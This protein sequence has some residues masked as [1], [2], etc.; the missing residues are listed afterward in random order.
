VP[1]G[2]APDPF[3]AVL[4]VVRV[5]RQAQQAALA[6]GRDLARQVEER[7]CGEHAIDDHADGAGL[8]QHEQP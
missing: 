2:T 3:E 6:A 1:S 8:L 7:V 5:K 4:R